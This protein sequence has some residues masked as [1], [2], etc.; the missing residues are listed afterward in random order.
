MG[1]MN[2]D[3]PAMALKDGTGSEAMVV[4][5]GLIMAL[6]KDGWDYMHAD[7]HAIGSGAPLALGAMA[8]GATARQAVEAA[9][10]HCVWTAGPFVELEA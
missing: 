4:H 2:G 3:P 6:S 8:V 10:A 1:G 7:Y 5:D 9:A